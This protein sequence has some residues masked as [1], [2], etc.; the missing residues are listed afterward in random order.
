[1]VIHRSGL[2]LGLNNVIR[3]IIIILE[4][5]GLK[6]IVEI[7]FGSRGFSKNI[8]PKFRNNL[9]AGASRSHQKIRLTMRCQACDFTKRRFIREFM[10]LGTLQKLCCLMWIKLHLA[11]LSIR[12]LFA[13]GKNHSNQR[14]RNF[15]VSMAKKIKLQWQ[16][17]RC[18]RYIDTEKLI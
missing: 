11:L 12:K 5:Y 15:S 7:L 9:E 6:N 8:Y 18:D 1:M 3:H 14:F 13:Y 2:C 10:N 4:I 17:P 16:I